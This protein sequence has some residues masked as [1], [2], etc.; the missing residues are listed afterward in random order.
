MDRQCTHRVI[1]DFASNGGIKVVKRPPLQQTYF[2]LFSFKASLSAR[3]QSLRIVVHGMLALDTPFAFE[4]LL[5]KLVHLL[6]LDPSKS[7]VGTQTEAGEMQQRPS[8]SFLSPTTYTFSTSDLGSS[9]SP[10]PLLLGPLD[11]RSPWTPSDHSSLRDNVEYRNGRL[12]G[13]TLS[14]LIKRMTP[15]NPPVDPTFS[16]VFFLT[17]RLFSTP[18]DLADA[19]T[20]RYGLSPPKN[21]SQEDFDYWQREIGTPI[22][23]QVFKFINTWLEDYWLPDV[24]DGALPVL[25]SLLS[26][27]SPRDLPPWSAHVV[28]NL[29]HKRTLSDINTNI[30]AKNS[31]LGFFLNR[32]EA[33][34]PKV[35]MSNWLRSS[36]RKGKFKRISIKAFDTVELA[37]QLTILES[38]LFCAVRLDD[39]LRTGADGLTTPKSIQAIDQ[40]GTII[41]RWVTESI[42]NKHYRLATRALLVKFFI[43]VAYS[44]VSLNNFSTSWSILAALNSSQVS[45][46][47]WTFNSLPQKQKRQLKYLRKLLDHSNNHCEYRNKLKDV[48]TPAIPCLGLYIMDVTFCRDCY[49]S[50]RR[51]SSDPKMRVIN[52]S[53][54]YR[55]VDIVQDIQKFQVPYNLEAVPGFQDYITSVFSP[56][57]Q[58]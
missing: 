52:L 22:R 39:I 12:V 11:D 28:Q 40:F 58:A 17:F 49:P 30:D 4:L 51:S 33:Q 6:S 56:Y 3:H 31:N 50:Y 27:R 25:K 16:N 21:L 18:K 34:R 46:L 14:V 47:Q 26:R 53:K 2:L 38:E 55:L 29:L 8:A 42:I 43:K 36:L 41:T 5:R 44:C 10:V 13:A 24:D 1:N 23:R 37:R 7:S 48:V 20:D 35:H 45:R 15:V 9:Q 32:L 54:Y 19:L 57:K